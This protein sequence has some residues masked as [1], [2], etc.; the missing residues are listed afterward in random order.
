MPVCCHF[1]GIARIDRRRGIHLLKD[2]GRATFV[3]RPDRIVDLIAGCREHRLEPKRMQL[4]YPGVDREANLVLLEA[5]KNGQAEA[6]ISCGNTG[7]LMAVSML[8]LRKL[9]ELAC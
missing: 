8:L 2:R 4:V 1:S 5:V 6:V 9:P 7:A 3:Y